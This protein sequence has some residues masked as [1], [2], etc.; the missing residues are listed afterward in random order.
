MPQRPRSNHRRSRYCWTTV[1]N[2]L[3]TWSTLPL[4]S[5]AAYSPSRAVLLTYGSTAE[6]ANAIDGP[7]TNSTSCPGIMQSTSCAIWID[8]ASTLLVE[9]VDIS[10]DDTG[11]PSIDGVPAGA[12]GVDSS[13]PQPTTTHTMHRRT[14][15]AS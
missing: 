11:V 15:P 9:H 3:V 14:T 4:P 10:N 7:S 1:R 6:P 12:S 5:T 13:P 8:S 2:A